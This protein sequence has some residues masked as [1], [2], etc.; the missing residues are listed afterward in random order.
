ML[1]DS[2]SA[3]DTATEQ[4]I[5]GYL[6]GEL[7]DKTAIIVTHRIYGLLDFDRIIVLDEGRVVESGTHAELV[8]GDGYYAEQFERQRLEEV[9]AVD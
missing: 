5:L 8:A 9:S 2:L 3:V 4:K 7:A 6:N 1:D